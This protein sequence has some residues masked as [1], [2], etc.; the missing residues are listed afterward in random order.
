MGRQKPVLE[1]QHRGRSREPCGSLPSGV[2]V[3]T[4]LV[5]TVWLLVDPQ[6]YLGE[7]PTSIH[8]L[9]CDLDIC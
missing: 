4:S 1:L 3:L 9:S 2:G 5:C 6:I 7:L 8:L